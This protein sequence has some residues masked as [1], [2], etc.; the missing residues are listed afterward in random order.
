[1][2]ID[3]RKKTTRREGGSVVQLKRPD[4]GVRAPALNKEGLMAMLH[5]AVKNTTH[6]P[7]A[8]CKKRRK[9]RA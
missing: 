7:I 1:M 4:H 8:P 3:L 6:P 5:Q 2:L 9:R